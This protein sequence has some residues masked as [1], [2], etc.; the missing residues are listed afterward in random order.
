MNKFKFIGSV[1]L[2]IIIG[3]TFLNYGNVNSH[4][5]INKLIVDKFESANNVGDMPDF[6]NYS[7]ELYKP[8]LK[9]SFITKT[10]LFNPTNSAGSKF[11]DLSD[12]NYGID[13]SFT[14]EARSITPEKWIVHGGYAADVPEVPASLRHF[15]DPS[16]KEGE[17]YLTDK[18][19]SK[20]F[21]KLNSYLPN[22]KTNGIDWA[23]GT[24]GNY[25]VLEHIYTWEHGKK[26]FKGALEQSDLKIRNNY[27]AK[28]WRSLGET[29]HMIA[30]NGC[31]AHVRN[32]GHPAFPI[33]DYD[34]FGNS[35]PYEEL[36]E[37]KDISKFSKGS[38]PFNLR[39]SLRGAKT[40]KDIAEKL[41]IFT[42]ENFFSEETISGI[43]WRGSEIKPITN[44]KY[45]HKSPKISIDNYFNN[46]Y[47]KKI[48]K[49]DVL[50]CTDKWYFTKYTPIIVT[51]P[52]I[53]DKCVESQ[54]KVLI[55]AIREAGVNVMK[56]FIPKLKVSIKKIDKH[57]SIAG[58]I[59]H[60]T[61]EE[62]KKEI[63][64]N[65]PVK[66][67]NG[68][69]SE[70]LEINA[71]GG[72]FSGR[73]NVDKST[74]V[75]AEIEFGGIS[76][77][78]KRIKFEVKKEESTQAPYT[79]V[80]TK[81][82]RTGYDFIEAL[83]TSTGDELEIDK[84]DMTASHDQVSYWIEYVNGKQVRHNYNE[85]VKSFC[86]FPSRLV[87]G[88]NMKYKYSVSKTSNDKKH[89]CNPDFNWVSLDISG[90]GINKGRVNVN[91][92]EGCGTIQ[93]EGIII[94]NALSSSQISNFE[95]GIRT[96][97]SIQWVLGNFNSSGKN[98]AHRT[99][100]YSL[101]KN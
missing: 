22:P 71:K 50:L 65:G 75:V 67:L 82:E 57:G 91:K 58:T 14:E 16:R 54:A 90:A 4:P 21:R 31:P 99:F 101:V 8:K 24:G 19:N 62:Y 5:T 81:I 28:A 56:L 98:I 64:Y 42:N 77:S 25:G 60:E 47:V 73:I 79:W 46:Y 34:I 59:K 23:I 3:F 10:G 97:I 32:D 94:V 49:E 100:Y 27:M 69:G 80:L 29:L 9:G 83:P 30:D 86:H 88:T 84:D 96:S 41:A 76:V 92:I 1:I 36:M 43:D 51:Q 66:I 13:A 26:Y 37:L 12:Y 20:L 6:K 17:R 63:F 55:P 45:V 35:D 85:H 95:N 68:G 48:G 89:G 38:I 44:P 93:K 53:N 72:E 74:I 7:F 18:I 2:L 78:S 11:G 39:D 87:P 33:P 40:A 70:I 61:D 15:Y 52:F